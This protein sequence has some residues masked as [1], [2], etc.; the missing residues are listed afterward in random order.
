M[1]QPRLPFPIEKLNCRR[2]GAWLLCIVVLCVACLRAAIADETDVTQQIRQR[3]ERWSDANESAADIVAFYSRRHNAPAWREPARIAALT[4]AIAGIRADGL[5]PRDY[6]LARLVAQSAASAQALSPSQFAD[7]D[8]VATDAY[9]SAIRHLHSGKVDPRSVDAQY[10]FELRSEETKQLLRRAGEA[11]ERG[12]IDGIL[13]QARPQHPIYARLVHA[14]ARLREIEEQE[15]GW[16]EIPEGPVLKVG[17]AGPRVLSLRRR[18]QLAGY[19]SADASDSDAFDSAVDAGLRSFQ[20]EQYLK[21]DGQLGAQTRTALNLPI[22]ARINQVRVNLERARWLLPQLTG[23]YVLVDIAGYKVSY[24]KSGA[25]VWSARAQVGRPYR[26][27]PTF[28]AEIRAVTFNP[29]WT[30]PPTI[31]RKDL[32]PQIR[33]DPTSLA[34]AHIR[35]L[36]ESGQEV[37]AS[38]V[39]WK[40]P[41]GLTLRQDAGPQ[42]ALGRVVIRF[43]NPYGV[44]IHDTPHAELFS[45]EQRAFSS[46]CIRLD[47]PLEL[48]ELLLADTPGW[49]RE[50]IRKAVEKGEALTVALEHPVTLLSMYWSLD[51]HNGSR[52]AFKPDIYGRDADILRALDSRNFQ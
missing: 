26:Y 31:L 23:D 35:V 40:N 10:T 34:R 27:T 21:A 51:T 9:L 3:I 33:A 48:V 16:P 22:A 20:S 38:A 47:R 49:G 45:R 1:R 32:L 4:S 15:G 52:I 24:F 5:D 44:Y 19:L 36:D 50:N 42:N 41:R 25:L 8:L 28:K 43:A 18:L 46:G 39:D 30:V 12:E 6:H 14:L 37:S 13:A 7:F 29:T 2:H 17:D 11:V